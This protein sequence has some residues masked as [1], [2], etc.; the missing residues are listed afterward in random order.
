MKIGDKLQELNKVERGFTYSLLPIDVTQGLKFPLLNGE[1]VLI[2]LIRDK[3]GIE[4][5]LRITAPNTTIVLRTNIYQG[6]EFRSPEH[7]D[8]H[9][10]N[11][12]LNVHLEHQ[13]MFINDIK[14][15]YQ[16]FYPQSDTG[17]NP[18]AKLVLKSPTPLDVDILPI[19]KIEE[20][21]RELGV[22]PPKPNTQRR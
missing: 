20:I 3:D 16:L 17:H 12:L 15:G 8:G 5:R 1:Q 10:T 9:Y 7:P 19:E 14:V 4:H 13:T 21:R 22:L 6:T 11:L 2:N 18:A